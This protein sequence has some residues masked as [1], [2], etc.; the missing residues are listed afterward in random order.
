MTPNYLPFFRL[1]KSNVLFVL[2]LLVENPSLS[3]MVS[4][5]Y[6]VANFSNISVFRGNQSKSVKYTN[7]LKTSRQGDHKRLSVEREM[8]LKLY[9]LV[10]SYIMSSLYWISLTEV[11]SLR[12]G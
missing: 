4:F 12:D 5:D 7:F 1:E 8:R 11:G 10:L 2:H 6:N 9:E 3:Y